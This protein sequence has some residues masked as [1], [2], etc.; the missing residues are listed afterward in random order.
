MK[1]TNVFIGEEDLKD[2]GMTLQAYSVQEYV[3]ARPIGL[4]GLRYRMLYAFEVLMGRADIVIWKV[5]ENNR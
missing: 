5:K 2:H 1:G 3:T 4:I